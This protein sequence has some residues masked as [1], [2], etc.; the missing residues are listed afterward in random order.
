MLEAMA[1]GTPVAAYPVDGP[2]EVLA[3]SD[4]GCMRD[5]LREAF[6]RAMALPRQAARQRALQFSWGE[7]AQRFLQH[8]V[9]CHQPALPGTGRQAPSLTHVTELSQTPVRL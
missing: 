2:L 1:C 7:A 6:F 3:D 9:P 8:L 5:D 4:G